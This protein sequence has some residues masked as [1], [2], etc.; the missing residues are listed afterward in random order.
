MNTNEMSTALTDK[1]T[2]LG[3]AGEIVDAKHGPVVTTFLFKPAPRTRASSVEKVVDDL[4]IALQ[5]RVRL[6]SPMEGLP[7]IGIE[8]PNH[9]RGT[10]K[11][12]SLLW[13]MAPMHWP[14]PLVFPVG[15]DTFGGLVTADLREL[16]HLLVA[17][18][19]GSGKSNFLHTLILSLMHRNTY[20]K[21]HFIL[22]D[23]KAVEFAAYKGEGHV[24]GGQAITSPE[25]AI[26]YLQHL[27]TEVDD[28]YNQMVAKGARR[29]SQLG[30][31][32]I[33]VVID[34]LADLMMVC[35]KQLEPLITRIA[36][37]ARAAGVHLVLATQRPSV[38]IVTGVIKANLPA[39]LCFRVPTQVDSRVILDQNG[40]ESL[41]GSG[42]GLFLSP[43]SP[44]GRIQA[45][46]VSDEILEK[47]L[48]PMRYKTKQSLLAKWV[49]MLQIKKWRSGK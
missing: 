13:E 17:G 44:L 37:K 29:A 10:L 41:I 40:A 45:G 22:I 26:E 18:T 25:V 16:P 46:Y 14:S 19:T 2:A 23:A 36:Q 12:E 35:R 5:G 39:R 11:F 42:D 32:D 4:S 1:L 27:V 30:L 31:P 34:E 3:L 48:A 33:V 49:K 6:L 21:V 28:R 20:D 15:A 47:V 38:D 7:Y 9:Q 24:I 43:A 8:V